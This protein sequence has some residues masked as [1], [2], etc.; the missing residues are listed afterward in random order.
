MSTFLAPTIESF[1]KETEDHSCSAYIKFIQAHPIVK[2]RITDYFN[3]NNFPKP[4]AKIKGVKKVIGARVVDR[5]QVYVGLETQNRV[6]EQIDNANVEVIVKSVNQEGWNYHVE[7]IVVEEGDFVD[8]ETGK[9]YKYRLVN[10]HHR[11]IAIFLLGFVT[12]PVVVV[13]FE[14]DFQRELFARIVSNRSQLTTVSKPYTFQDAHHMIVKAKECGR[15]KDDIKDVEKFVKNYLTDLTDKMGVSVRKLAEKLCSEVGVAFSQFTWNKATI[16]STLAEHFSGTDDDGNY[17]KN[18]STQGSFDD[19]NEQGQI[20]CPDH[21]ANLD[22]FAINYFTQ[23]VDNEEQVKK[24][25]KNVTNVY[26]G[27][28]KEY[29][30]KQTLES[31]KKTLESDLQERLKKVA[32]GATMYLNGQ[33]GLINPKW[34]ATDADNGETMNELY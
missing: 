24:V 33:G 4:L 26:L 11:F 12:L 8:P 29:K 23:L 6:G 27:L 25:G 28:Q 13:E 10:G 20:C 31:L 5:D 17:F 14:D 3:E 18:Y 34:M 30:G 22:N 7:Q 16:E 2:Q 21:S 1:A 32:K 19:N 9:K 15:I